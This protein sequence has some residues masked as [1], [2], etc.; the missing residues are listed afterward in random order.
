[1]PG[2]WGS[3]YS[4]IPNQR[5]SLL[6]ARHIAKREHLPLQNCIIMKKWQFQKQGCQVL[7]SARKKKV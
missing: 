1:M 6:S 3:V 4:D 5:A 7:K 2:S